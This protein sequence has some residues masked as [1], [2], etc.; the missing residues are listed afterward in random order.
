MLSL[1]TGVARS[2]EGCAHVSAWADPGSS[3]G[4][5]KHGAS[6]LGRRRTRRHGQVAGGVVAPGPA[7]VQIFS[8]GLNGLE[9]GK[10]KWEKGEREAFA[11]T[12]G[13]GTEGS[14]QRLDVG[15]SGES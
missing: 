8:D 7:P 2:A 14:A 1:C 5:V 3:W 12:C 10:M 11:M 15:G 6:R 9:G 13:G 4:G